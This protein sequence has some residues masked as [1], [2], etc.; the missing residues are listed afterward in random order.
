MSKRKLNVVGVDVAVGSHCFHCFGDLS[1]RPASSVPTM[2]SSTGK[3]GISL[4]PS[5]NSIV[6]AKSAGLFEQ[7]FQ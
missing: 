7:L 3:L 5:L 4:P 2:Q 1:V 6:S